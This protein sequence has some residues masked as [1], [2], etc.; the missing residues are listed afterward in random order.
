MPDFNPANTIIRNGWE[1]LAP[2]VRAAILDGFHRIIGEEITPIFEG[3]EL[4]EIDGTSVDQG[5]ILTN[6]SLGPAVINM[7]L[8]GDVG[9]LRY[10]ARFLGASA[11]PT[12]P[13]GATL[14]RE[15]IWDQ[16]Q[17]DVLFD[18]T[19]TVQISRDNGFVWSAN[20]NSSF[21]RRRRRRTMD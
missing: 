21:V 17:T 7:R 5:D 14:A 15:H 9:T 2:G 8:R 20:N 4:G 6:I 12:T 13:A 1:Q 18:K 19:L 16:N 3:V 10:L 11:T